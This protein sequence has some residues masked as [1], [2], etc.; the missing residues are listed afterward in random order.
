MAHVGMQILF[1]FLFGLLFMHL[2]DFEMLM[3][4]IHPAIRF[5]A[6]V[7][8]IYFVVVTIR[9]ILNMIFGGW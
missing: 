4:G 2:L 1:Y 3:D 7:L 9:G 8:A 6:F 5:I